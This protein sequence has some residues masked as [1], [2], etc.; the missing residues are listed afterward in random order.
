MAI[1]RSVLHV[2]PSVAARYGGP[3]A[4][5]LGMCKVLRTRGIDARIA[6]TDADGPGRLA[7]KTGE[8]GVF[9]GIPTIFFRRRVSESYKWSGALAR[10]LKGHVADFDVVHVHAVFSHASV[11]AGVACAARQV[12]YLIRPLGTLDPWSVRRRAWRKQVLL[13]LG[14]SGLMRRAG[15]MHYTTPEE[16][17]LAEQGFAPLPAGVVVPVGID[18]DCFG[19]SSE[20]AGDQPYAIVMSRLDPKKRIEWAIGAW[21]A[22]MGERCTTPWRL[23][24][25]G[26]GTPAY[27]AHLES[28]AASGPASHLIEFSGWLS[29]EAKASMLRRASLFVMPSSQENFGISMAE[30]LASGVPALVT[31]G[32]NLGREVADAEAGWLVADTEIAVTNGVANVVAHPDE[33]ARRGRAARVFAERFRWSTVADDLVSMYRGVISSASARRETSLS[34][35]IGVKAGRT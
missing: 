3:S 11:A 33:C 31:P 7:V 23:V 29:G 19:A 15:A 9:S 26:E 30:G 27:R 4:A 21:H 13:S 20:A 18:D 2:I 25:A 6:T 32:V 28:L 10:W 1:P 16:M 35:A 12:P 24:I 8:F 17:E 5:V 14:A 22:V 34:T